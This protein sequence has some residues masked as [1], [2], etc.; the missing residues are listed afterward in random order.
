MLKANNDLELSDAI[1]LFL[2]Q[3]V[4]RGGIA[5]C[6]ARI[7]VFE[8]SR[9]KTTVGFILKRWQVTGA[10]TTSLLRAQRCHPEAMLLLVAVKRLQGAHIEWPDGPLSD[11]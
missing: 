8:S 1:R 7:P 3:V 4:R 9:E 11:D 10:Q 6:G 2:R 5:L